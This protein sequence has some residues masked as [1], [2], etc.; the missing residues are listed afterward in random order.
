LFFLYL[1][2]IALGDAFEDQERGDKA[3]AL[4][5]LVGSV[6]LP[7]VH[8]SVEWWNTLHQPAI[9][10]MSGFSVN[11][12]MLWPLLTMVGAFQFYFIAVLV[13]RV[14][15]EVLAAKIRTARFS[16]ASAG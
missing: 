6:N 4:L 13:V 12:A 14:R 5:A 8:F 1:G 11:A 10:D 9:F 15:S 3:Q 16:M 2:Y 7:I